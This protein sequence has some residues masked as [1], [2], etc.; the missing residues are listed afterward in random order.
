M[1]SI[2]QVDAGLERLPGVL[3]FLADALASSGLDDEGRNDLTVAV[4]EAF[5]NIAQHSGGTA[6]PVELRVE[7]GGGK[8]SV[9][10]SDGGEPF[11]PLAAPEPDLVSGPEERP[12][13]GLGIHLIRALVDHA[14]YERADARN[15]LTLTMYCPRGGGPSTRRRDEE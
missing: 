13:G 7:T 12:V 10:L 9:R 15:I 5:T 4:E 3:S 6:S 14:R 1:M 8:V 11:D 2:I